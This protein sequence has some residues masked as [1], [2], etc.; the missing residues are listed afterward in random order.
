MKKADLL[1]IVNPVL[2]LLTLD[3][4]FSGI[5]RNLVPMDSSFALPYT[6]FKTVH[7]T[8]GYAL[9]VVGLMHIYLNW[10]W[11]KTTFFKKKKIGSSE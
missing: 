8:V 9:V 11:I 6:L 3:Q 5:Y 1:K 2:A 10:S 4:A 7:T